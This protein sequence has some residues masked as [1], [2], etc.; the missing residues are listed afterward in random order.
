MKFDVEVAGRQCAVIVERVADTGRFRVIVDGRAHDLEA[1]P[2]DLGWSLVFDEGRRSIDAAAT[3]QNGGE[4]LVQL[5]GD[6]RGKFSEQRH[7]A[8]PCQFSLLLAGPFK[9]RELAGVPASR[10]CPDYSGVG[11][12][13]NQRDS[14]TKPPRLPECGLHHDRHAR[15][16]RR[17]A[18]IHVRGGGLE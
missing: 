10:V 14:R 8:N 9:F 18:S 4:W 3:V 2:T 17:C 7:A 6:R 15:H 1:R 12:Y 16:I 5:V 11:Y 13:S